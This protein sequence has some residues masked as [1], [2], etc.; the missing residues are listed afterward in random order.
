MKKWAS[1]CYVYLYLYVCVYFFVV[2]RT[3]EKKFNLN[4]HCVCMCVCKVNIQS[5]LNTFVNQ[6]H[7]I[8]LSDP[9]SM[10]M[11]MTMIYL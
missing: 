9:S 2:A 10:M 6:Y 1:N 3:K 8:F 7:L 5:H 4:I 11:M